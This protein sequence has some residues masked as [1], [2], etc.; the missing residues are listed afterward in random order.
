MGIYSQS[1]NLSRQSSA[2]DLKRQF[3][4]D[5]RRSSDGFGDGFS[6]LGRGLDL[7]R[8][9]VID[10]TDITAILHRRQKQKS[11]LY[12]YMG[13]FLVGLSLPPVCYFYINSNRTNE[14]VHKIRNFL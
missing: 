6:D 12:R 11:C 4:A 2:V 14:L 13:Q 7:G 8:D 10:P 3:S 1:N 5:R 9:S